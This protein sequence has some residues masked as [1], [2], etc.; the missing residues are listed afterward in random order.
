MIVFEK[1][2]FLWTVTLS[3]LTWG[4]PIGAL[5]TPASSAEKAPE[6]EQVSIRLGPAPE[7]DPPLKH[8]L[9][10]PFAELRSGNAAIFYYRAMLLM[11]RQKEAQFGDPQSAWLEMPLQEI[12]KEEIKRFLQGFSGSLHEL[13]QAA[14]RES[15]DWE[16]GLRELDGGDVI[17]FLLP[18]LQEARQLGR[19]VRLKTRLAIAEGDF[20]EALRSLQL[21]YSLARDLGRSPTLIHGLVGIAVASLMHQ[22]VVDWIDVQGPNLYWALASLPDPLVDLRIAMQQEMHL[23]LQFFPFL[24]DPENQVWS[25]QQWRDALAEGIDQMTKVHGDFLAPAEG[26]VDRQLL[27]QFAAVG[28]LMTFYPRRSRN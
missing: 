13:E 10:V 22:S 1:R 3:V 7:V 8:S 21:G 17:S 26:K 25:E 9:I 4:L 23:P 24:K 6:I 27:S 5:Q 11:P 18:E 19:V 12:P 16:L 2:A 20:D 28:W 14:Q 15:C